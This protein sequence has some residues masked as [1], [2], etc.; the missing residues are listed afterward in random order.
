MT[1]ATDYIS[2]EDAKKLANRA[3]WRGWLVAM[4]VSF[5]GTVF[6][7]VIMGVWS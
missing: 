5:S 3:F 1:E 2:V 4:V 6:A 7:Q